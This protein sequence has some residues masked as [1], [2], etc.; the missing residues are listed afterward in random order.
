MPIKV[1]IDSLL[2][3]LLLWYYESLINEAAGLE[4]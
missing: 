2:K 3:S 1:V 4:F